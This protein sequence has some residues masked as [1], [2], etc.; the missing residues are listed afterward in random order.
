[1]E[2][3]LAIYHNWVNQIESPNYELIP[4]TK[5]VE[6]GEGR[7]HGLTIVGNGKFVLNQS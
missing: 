5:G 1:M 3:S 7:S 2:A 4:L 6:A